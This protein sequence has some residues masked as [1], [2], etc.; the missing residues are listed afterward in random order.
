MYLHAIILCVH[1]HTCALF[2][3]RRQE[4]SYSNCIP[5]E[6]QTSL[7]GGGGG[8][9][10]SCCSKPARAGVQ[11]LK[12]ATGPEIVTLAIVVLVAVQQR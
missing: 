2:G 5:G 9:G 3:G 4:A 7:V 8:G 1:E 11:V 12:A 6:R 10:G